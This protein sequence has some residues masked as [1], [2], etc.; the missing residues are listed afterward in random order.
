MD[1][2]TFNSATVVLGMHRSG[3]SALAGVLRLCSLAIPKSLIP[4][5]AANE[6][7]FW[8]SEPI[9]ALNDSAL[10]LLGLN[11][12]A[13]G[14]IEP[15]SFGMT[16]FD[17][18]RLQA[19]SLLKSEFPARSDIVLKDPRLCRTL[20]LWGPALDQSSARLGF[21]FII[22]NPLEVAESLAERND[23]YLD[24]ALLLWVR[25][26]LDAEL[27]TRGSRRAFTSFPGLIDD[28]RAT[29][30][31]MASALELPIEMNLVDAEAI[32]DYV[33][34]ALRHHTHADEG[35]LDGR[36]AQ[37]RAA[38]RI[39]SRWA[40]GEAESAAA[41]REL[42]R[43][44]GGL[45]SV[46]VPLDAVLEGSRLDRKR[47]RSARAELQKA[48]VELSQTRESAR[49]LD[50][51]RSALNA[52]F[53][54]LAV[55]FAERAALERALADSAEVGK[56]LT[57]ER[58]TLIA[59]HR[60]ALDRALLESAA[61]A[62]RLTDERD[63]LIASQAEER[64]AAS[65]RE[66]E[67]EQALAKVRVEAQ[68][69]LA[70]V[71]EETDLRSAL[72]AG[73]EKLA[74][75][76][77]ERAALERALVESAAVA[78]RL[79]DERDALIASQAEEREAASRRETEHEQAL[80]KVRKETEE[81]R[82]E[83]ASL[84]QQRQSADEELGRVKHKYRASQYDVERERKAHAITKSKL[85][86]TTNK[87]ARYERSA[88]WRAYLA[89][90]AFWRRTLGI[91]GSLNGSSR[92]RRREQLSTIAQSG[93]FDGRWYLAQYP[94]VAAA[95][96]DPLVHFAK[97]GWREGRDPGPGFRTSAYLKVNPDV[98][99]TGRNPLLHYIEYGRSEGRELQV[100][101]PSPEPS[102][103]AIAH[104]FPDPAPVFRGELPQKAAVRWTRSY[105][106]SADDLRAVGQGGLVVGLAEQA[107]QRDALQSEFERLAFLSGFAARPASGPRAGAIGASASLIDAWYFNAF[108]LRTRWHDRE[109]PF[110]ARA[111]QHDPSTGALAIVGETLV[112]S[113]LDLVD[114]NL[115][116]PYFPVLFLFAGTEGT[117]RGTCLLA[118]PS[119]CRGGLHYAELLAHSPEAP[120]P[121]REGLLQAGRFEDAK[122]NPQR[123]IRLIALNGEGG[124]GTTPIFD[125]L[126]RNWLEKVASVTVLEGSGETALDLPFDMVSSLS[127][128]GQLRGKAT[129]KAST[130][131]LPIVV[132]GCEPSQPATSIGLP[133]RSPASLA[134][135]ASGYPSPWPVLDAPGLRVADF[136]G[137][138]AIRQDSGRA[139]TDAEM[140]VPAIGPSLAMPDTPGD[141]LTWLVVP[142]EWRSDELVQ[143]LRALSLQRHSPIHS[144][145][146]LGEP[147][148]NA[149]T[150]AA[151]LFGR[152]A[153]VFHDR[154]SAIANVATPLVGYLGS[155]V[156]LHDDRSARFLAHLLDDAEVVS[157][158]CTLVTPE[159][160]GKGWHVSV[161]DGGSI[162]GTAEEKAA[163]RANLP[164]L[165]W[166]A[167][168]PVEAPPRDLWIA[169]TAIV[170]K[171][172]Q[173]RPP[174]R[175]RS[176]FHLCTT[177][178]TAS[179]LGVPGEVAPE[180]RVP[181]VAPSSSLKVREMFG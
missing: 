30:E 148:A 25:Y 10:K 119:L 34:P 82:A 103:P 17:S 8:E 50:D 5:G 167:T 97:N 46:A 137:P 170:E 36:F 175:V 150:L 70:R 176:G 93:L 123:L 159:R 75:S 142:Q 114:L 56:R 43:I 108:G 53:E 124:D 24:H 138:A 181:P 20:P 81:L 118:F 160:R 12:H 141:P 163:F 15:D 68:Q 131:L 64:E 33:A 111:Y 86:D 73:F 98:A 54:K 52:S 120:D 116:D 16:R 59:N 51:L 166:R 71:R 92:R 147:D 146:F 122:D 165:L 155:G 121:V 169:R 79:T 61:V 127:I 110:V 168:Y 84:G 66:T 94:D 3:T 78:K 4:S 19:R 62:K 112:E 157:A 109:R 26:M 80:A 178:V 37:V 100:R 143:S 125:P 55:S 104:D 85:V 11:W 95:G 42:D 164:K 87:L 76:F 72:D 89:V 179:Y 91:A 27:E 9:K 21:A 88:A 45:D 162:P 136:K 77:A 13:L 38:Y 135:G 99:G 39:F 65:R 117:V 129:E 48:Q 133:A 177:L 41:H 18:L 47:V 96:L 158:A 151:D 29:V 107:E 128:L 161:A 140:L 153:A 105:Q 67:H 132:A 149:A 60:A 126:F 63:A 145:A 69:V 171:W 106:L 44:R 1:E 113:D 130:A 172:M 23:M 7:G 115:V 2:R 102:P 40:A 83:I 101:R 32:D 139:L 134:E 14:Q 74:A 180:I 6:K 173:S 58:A 144:I 28:W 154:A 57:D 156:I 49:K 152:R 31:R 22:R 90:V 35:S 174:Q